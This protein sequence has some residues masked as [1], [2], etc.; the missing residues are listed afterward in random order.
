MDRTFALWVDGANADA[1]AVSDRKYVAS[2]VIFI[3]DW[4]IWLS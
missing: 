4:Q 1:D 3:V 2:D